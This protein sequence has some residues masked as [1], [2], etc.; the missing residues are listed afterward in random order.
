MGLAMKVLGLVCALGN[1]LATTAMAGTPI[2]FVTEPKFIS[3]CL[4]T[5]EA[6]PSHMNCLTMH[7]IQIGVAAREFTNPSMGNMINGSRSTLVMS[8]NYGWKPGLE[9]TAMEVARA[10][11]KGA[12]GINPS[13]GGEALWL[14]KDF[15][16][17]Q[18]HSMIV[19]KPKFSDQPVVH[20]DFCPK[21][22][23]MI[24][25]VTVPLEDQ[26]VYVHPCGKVTPI[27]NPEQVFS[28]DITLMS[29]ENGRVIFTSGKYQ[30]PKLKN[31]IRNGP[32]E[33]CTPGVIP[34]TKTGGPPRT[35][36]IEITPKLG[37]PLSPMVRGA[38]KSY[39]IGLFT[40]AGINYVTT[41]EVN[42]A[43]TAGTAM[44]PFNLSP[45]PQGVLTMSEQFRRSIN[46]YHEGIVKEVIVSDNPVAITALAQQ[47]AMCGSLGWT[48]ETKSSGWFSDFVAGLFSLPPF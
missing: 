15:M 44:S 40:T 12:I 21:T 28:Q 22:G 9:T 16:G 11:G 6:I 7:G 48:G 5:A 23:R 26:Y 45:G 3:S 19:P 14:T 13:L 29:S 43:N 18:M 38:L 30:D 10:T 42:W 34:K 41:G 25:Y 17:Q 46:D 32:G 37:T 20:S 8:C 27:K 39:G 36:P 33:G 24:D 2:P 1:L 47:Q 35:T 31:F 4:R